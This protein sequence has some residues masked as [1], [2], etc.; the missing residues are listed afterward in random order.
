MYETS[1]KF[2]SILTKYAQGAY[3]NPGDE[4]DLTRIFFPTLGVEE[5]HGE[6][7]I[8]KSKSA[9]TAVDTSM[10][11]DNTPRRLQLDRTVG[12]FN[13]TPHGLEISRS[14]FNDMQKSGPRY[15][16]A[17]LRTLMSA[18]FASRQTATVKAVKAAKAAEDSLGA[19]TSNSTADV[20]GQ[21]EQLCHNVVSGTG[22][23]PT[24][25]LIGRTAWSKLR[26][27]PTIVNRINGISYAMP[28]EAF[29]TLLAYKGVKL[30]V[31][32]SMTMVNGAMTELLANDVIAL[33]NQEAPTVS[34]M[35]FAKEFTLSPNGPEVLSYEEH[36]GV[37]KV[38]MLLWSSD[39][40]VTNANAMSRLVVS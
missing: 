38:D 21:I 18:Q 2:N 39:C 12:V 13:C 24:D 34:D 8:W 31:V 37:N 26:N 7:D 10:A 3:L 25:I 36:G 6:F 20:I 35:S 9:L 23:K 15:Q 11:R 22:C 17:A 1:D 28:E 29:L 40:K 5:A 32:D 30:T 19:W 33:Y 27:H 4:I 14:A 16:E